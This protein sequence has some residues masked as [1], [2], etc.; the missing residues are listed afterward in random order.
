MAVVEPYR[1]QADR[2]SQRNDAIRRSAQHY[3]DHLERMLRRY[4]LE[5][6]HFDSFLDP[7]VDR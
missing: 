3:A 6:F 4:P 7:R 5:W 1:V 2:R